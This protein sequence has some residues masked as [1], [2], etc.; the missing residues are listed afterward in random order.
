MPYGFSISAYF[1]AV[2]IEPNDLLADGNFERLATD[3]LTLGGA[4][5]DHEMHAQIIEMYELHKK[6]NL[7]LCEEA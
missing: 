5:V 2:L 7:K 4:A 3:M 6:H 1:V